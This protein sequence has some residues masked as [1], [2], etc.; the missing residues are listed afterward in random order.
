M[1]SRPNM[2]SNQLLALLAN[3]NEPQFLKFTI[4]CEGGTIN[5][6]TYI[7]VLG[8]SEDIPSNSYF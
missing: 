8:Y 4:R 2:S 3:L 1:G 6:L 5:I 7:I